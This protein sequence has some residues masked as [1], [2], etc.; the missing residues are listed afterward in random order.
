MKRRIIVFLQI[1]ML[2]LMC[3]PA[4]AMADDTSTIT[5]SLSKTTAA[6]GDSITVSGTT[7]SGA[8]VPLKVVDGAGNIV[9]FDAAKANVNGSYTIAFKVPAGA[10]GTLAVVV[11]EG[12]NVVNKDLVVQTGTGGG[13]G[14][15]GGSAG[16]QPVTSTTGSAMVNP[17]AG[18]TISL[19]DEALVNIPADAL[20]GTDEV[21][22]T[23]TKVTTPPETPSGFRILGSV[24]EFSVE[25]MESYSFA[26]KVTITFSFDPSLLKPGETPA[27]YYYDQNKQEWVNLGGIVSGN[28]I[29]VEVDHFTQFAVLAQAKAPET[30][31][32]DISGHWAENNIRELV[33]LGA[34]GGYPDKTFKPDNNI[35]RAEFVSILVKSFKLEPKNGK[36][37]ADTIGHWAQDSIATAA[38]YGIVNGYDESTFGPNDTITREQMAAM[39][40]NAA[41]LTPAAAELFF[42]DSNSISGWAQQAMA[43]AVQN[44][45]ISGYPDNTVRPQGNATR[46]EAVTVIVNAL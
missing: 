11:G 42:V 34:I 28:T 2:L 39:I 46:A 27:I 1:A 21:E 40:V 36:T 8:W 5:M 44:G 18:G 43:T 15:G 3:F 38:S 26:G 29:T 16:P 19:A 9:V 4:V 37:F 6:V 14:G 22:V 31:L 7:A 32:T 25:G 33:A 13:G 17:R 23:V 10:S 35:T 20:N 45:I 24:Y 41:K 30:A 12:G